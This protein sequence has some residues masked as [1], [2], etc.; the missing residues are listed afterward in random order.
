LSKKGRSNAQHT[1]KKERDTH[2]LISAAKKDHLTIEVENIFAFCAPIYTFFRI[3][4]D[5]CFSIGVP[6]QFKATKQLL[7]GDV[8]SATRVEM[9]S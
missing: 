6:Y 3:V 1:A 5:A 8:T 7:S 2:K 4:G 9:I